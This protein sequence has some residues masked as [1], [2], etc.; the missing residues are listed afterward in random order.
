MR[1]RRNMVPDQF[2]YDH[3]DMNPIEDF[4]WNLLKK[5]VFPRLD[6]IQNMPDIVLLSRSNPKDFQRYKIIS[7]SITKKSYKP[8]ESP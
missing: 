2:M 5:L 3:D 4:Y 1:F 6:E 7:P 8:A